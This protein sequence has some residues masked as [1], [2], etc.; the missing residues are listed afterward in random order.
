MTKTL[1]ITALILLF[2]TSITA[3][4]GGTGLIYDPSGEFMQM[5]K[6]FLQHSPF[7]NYLIPGILLLIFNGILSLI[8]AILVI[9]K[10]PYGY[11]FTIFQ[12]V[13]L[14]IWL[15]V[16]IVMVKVFFIPMHLPYYIIGISLIF[17]GWHLHRQSIK[18][19]PID[20]H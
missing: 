8:T 6:E 14:I 15:S 7:P 16:Q 3:I 4:W 13:I 9:R 5:S 17:L 2:F 1:R 11:Q 19:P 18:Y 12:G 20:F 10:H